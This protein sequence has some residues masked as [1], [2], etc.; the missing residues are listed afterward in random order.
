M[1]DPHELLDALLGSFSDADG[2]KDYVTSILQHLL[3]PARLIDGVSRYAKGKAPP[4]I[5]PGG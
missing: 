2:G 3:I 4:S 5:A 1:N